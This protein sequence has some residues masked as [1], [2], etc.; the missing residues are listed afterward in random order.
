MRPR[1][2]PFAWVEKSSSD[3]E[4]PYWS[5]IFGISLCQRSIPSCRSVYI[6]LQ[7]WEAL[8]SRFRCPIH[9]DRMALKTL[10]YAG[11]AAYMP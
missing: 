9:R 3:S 11:N 5:N 7:V 4:W 6:D 8:K 1:A 2:M 10:S